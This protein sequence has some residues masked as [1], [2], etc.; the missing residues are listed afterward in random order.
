MVRAAPSADL[1][2][3][4][5]DP[6]RALEL[7]EFATLTLPVGRWDI[8]VLGED[9]EPLMTMGPLALTDGLVLTID[10]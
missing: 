5:V 1:L 4:A 2:L 7:G 6:S 9:G 3:T 10:Y 8:R